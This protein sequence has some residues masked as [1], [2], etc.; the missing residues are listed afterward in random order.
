M[1]DEI[2]KGDLVMAIRGCPRC[3]ARGGIVFRVALIRMHKGLGYRCP[4]CGAE[5]LHFGELGAE[6]YHKHR[7][8]PLSWLK[9]IDPPASGDEVT[10]RV[11]L[12]I[13]LREKV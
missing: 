5:G 1:A 4:E 6:G 9:K 13:H 10:D 12:N 2:K 8:M 11:P 3:G 7:L